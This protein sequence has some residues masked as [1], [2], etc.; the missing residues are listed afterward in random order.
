[1]HTG[2]YEVYELVDK[3]LF[4]ELEP[5]NVCLYL[6][7]NNDTHHDFIS[8]SITPGLLYPEMFA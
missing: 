8:K 5:I 4:C 2:R 3:L 6:V 7:K 1:L